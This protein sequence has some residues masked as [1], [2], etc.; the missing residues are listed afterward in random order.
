MQRGNLFWLVGFQSKDEHDQATLKNHLLK[1]VFM[2]ACEHD[3]SILL[4]RLRKAGLKQVDQLVWTLLNVGKIHVNRIMVFKTARLANAGFAVLNILPMHPYPEKLS[5]RYSLWK[6]WSSTR[7]NLRSLL[8]ILLIDKE[9]AFNSK[10]YHQ[11][12]SLFLVVSLMAA[13]LFRKSHLI[14]ASQIQSDF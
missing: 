1:C 8:D 14:S 5:P 2:L 9:C 3:M 4:H 11:P 6:G 10:S 7:L 12:S 13:L